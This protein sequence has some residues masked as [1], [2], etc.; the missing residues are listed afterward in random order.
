[1]QWMGESDVFSP[2]VHHL[3][4]ES[5]GSWCI[6]SV[7]LHTYIL[8][9]LGVGSE[10]CVTVLTVKDYANQ[11]TPL[12][13]FSILILCFCLSTLSA[14]LQIPSTTFFASAISRLSV[15]KLY[16]TSVPFAFQTPISAAVWPQMGSICTP[17]IP[18]GGDSASWALVY[19]GHWGNVTLHSPAV[20]CL[21]YLKKNMRKAKRRTRI[22]KYH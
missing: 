16:W 1:M 15:L 6:H 17:P 5:D 2:T 22:Q 9:L 20:L 4:R 12:L 19:M 14:P 18:L 8:S 21:Q 3:H 13:F 7:G 11:P 10:R